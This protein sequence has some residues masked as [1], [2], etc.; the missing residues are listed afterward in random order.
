MMQVP[1]VPP[2][3]IPS[4]LPQDAVNRVLPNIQAQA[5]TP[6][7][8]RA[9]DPRPGSDRKSRTRSN[10]DDAKGGGKDGR[11]E[12]GGRGSSVNIRV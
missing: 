6:T 1:P 12:K 2:V 8:Q 7:I 3:I 10:E 4:Q 5:V 11:G 9:V